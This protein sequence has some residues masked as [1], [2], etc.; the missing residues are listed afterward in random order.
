MTGGQIAMLFDISRRYPRA[1]VH[2]HKLHTCTPPFTAVGQSEVVMLVTAIDSL[3]Q[4]EG[5]NNDAGRK[6]SIPNPTGASKLEFTK[7][8][9]YLKRP[10]I[11]ADN[12]FSSELIMEWLGRK[13]Y[14]MT[15]TCARNRIPKA[16]KPFTHHSTVDSTHARCKAMRFESPV[17]AIQQ[18]A[19]ENGAAAY[20]KTFVSFQSTG[21]TNIIGVNNLLSVRLYVGQKERGRKKDGS[22]R[23]YGIEQ[24]EARELYLGHYYGLDN[25]DHMIKNAGNRYITWKYWHA[26]YLHAQSLGIIAAYDM[27]IECCEGTLDASWAIPQKLRMSFSQFRIRLSEQMLTYNPVDNLYPGDKTFRISTK[28]HKT[29]RTSDEDG[30][31][32]VGPSADGVTLEQYKAALESGRLCITLEQI[33]EHFFSVYAD[34]G[35]NQLACE[36]CGTK[37]IWRCG[38]CAKPMCTTRKRTWSGGR[39]IFAYHSHDFFGLSRSDKVELE[40][41]DIRTWTSPN[42]YVV[43]KNA[44]KINRWKRELWNMI[45]DKVAAEV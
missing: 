36:V 34:K 17:V 25:A 6:V 16:I 5:D 44:R 21:G 27:Y 15:A 40:G 35:N 26:P 32:R 1:Y 41:K 43:S 7:K 33:R 4:T 11:T 20:T 10:H 22:K 12:F 38:K 14:G 30:T 31:V 3:L 8:P 19:A 29:R 24:N 2:R 13:G 23:V 42:S 37:T 39:C 28:T 9:I 18:H 45:N